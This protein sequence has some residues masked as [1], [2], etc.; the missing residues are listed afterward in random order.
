MYVHKCCFPYTYSIII[1]YRFYS[2]DSKTYF[3]ICYLIS[4]ESI[5]IMLFIKCFIGIPTAIHLQRI[6]GMCN[7]YPFTVSLKFLRAVLY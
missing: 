5:N 4:Y 6:A 1:I 7:G 3:N 2:R